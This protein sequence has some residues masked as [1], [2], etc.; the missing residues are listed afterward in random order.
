MLEMQMPK[1]EGKNALHA[2]NTS[3]IHSTNALVQLDFHHCL[4]VWDFL[5]LLVREVKADKQREPK[6]KQ[7]KLN[8]R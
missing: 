2:G 8:E 7:G 5:L 4:S 3:F 1:I 6:E